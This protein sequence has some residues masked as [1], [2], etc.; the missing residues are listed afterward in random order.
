MYCSMDKL[1][2]HPCMH[3]SMHQSIYL[4]AVYNAHAAHHCQAAAAAAATARRSRLSP[5]L[6]CASPPSLP[7]PAPAPRLCTP[8]GC[9]AVTSKNTSGGHGGLGGHHLHVMMIPSVQS[10]ECCLASAVNYYPLT[11]SSSPPPPRQL[12]CS[13]RRQRGDCSSALSQLRSPPSIH[14][15]ELV[16]WLGVERRRG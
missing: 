14:V 15:G 12:A 5:L 7:Y 10:N 13:T 6:C 4:Y 11:L 9:A 2:L 16:K 3:P 1:Q 8:R